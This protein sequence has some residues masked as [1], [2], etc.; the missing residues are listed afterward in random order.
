MERRD[1]F[2]HWKVRMS[3]LILARD[4]SKEISIMRRPGTF[5]ALSRA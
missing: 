5:E 2:V 4:V 3:D 1:F